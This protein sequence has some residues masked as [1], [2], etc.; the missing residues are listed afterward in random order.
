MVSLVNPLAGAD[1]LL[2]GSRNLKGWGQ[3][4]RPDATLLY[5]RGFDPGAQRFAYEVNERFGDTQSARTAIRSPFQVGLQVR[6]QLG[7]DRQRDLLM[8]GLRAIGAPAGGGRG[9]V[10]VAFLVERVA[11][12]PVDAIVA[13]RD[14]VALTDA[15]VAALQ[16]VS[17]SLRARTAVV[18]AELQRMVDSVGTGGDLR[19]LF[20]RLQ[21]TLQTA[22]ELYLRALRDAEAAMTPAQW[23]RLPESLRNPRLPQGPGAARRRPPG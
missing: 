11:P 8:A 23:Q 14:S 1:R 13:L 5:V 2:H 22:R 12:N 10:D 19:T 16:V 7:P 4:D 9:G 6:L 20:P 17:D 18:V 15:Q 3:P 21:P